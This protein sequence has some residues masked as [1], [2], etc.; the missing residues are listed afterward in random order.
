MT[1]FCACCP[2]LTNCSFRSCCE[3]R[4]CWPGGREA[5]RKEDISKVSRRNYSA[6]S[7]HGGKLLI[8]VAHS[9]F[10]IMAS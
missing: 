2:F 1:S 5:A 8:L 10:S 3:E 7:A 6:Y 9:F 4:E